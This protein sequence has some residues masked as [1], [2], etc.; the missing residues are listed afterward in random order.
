MSA[1]VL[2][3]IL[4]PV[5]GYPKKKDIVTGFLSPPIVNR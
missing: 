3:F 1:K 5:P 2:G 4:F